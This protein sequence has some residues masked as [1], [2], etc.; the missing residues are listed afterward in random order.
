VHNIVEDDMRWQHSLNPPN[1]LF[2]WQICHLTPCDSNTWILRS[3]DRKP[4]KRTYGSGRP[5]A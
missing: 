1:L 5:T 3:N 2:G 4:R